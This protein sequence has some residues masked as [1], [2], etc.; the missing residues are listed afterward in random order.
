MR[1]VGL[2]QK[3][4]IAMHGKPEPFIAEQLLGRS[5]ARRTEIVARAALGE[6]LGVGIPSEIGAETGG[7]H[8]VAQRHVAMRAACGERHGEI[9]VEDRGGGMHADAG[10]NQHPRRG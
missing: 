9:A 3:R 6:L 10:R 1:A 4:A 7:Q 5:D 2:G 8:R